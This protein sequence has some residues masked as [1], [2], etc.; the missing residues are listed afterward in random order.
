MNKSRLVKLVILCILGM[1]LAI[2]VAIVRVERKVE[3][4]NK[5]TTGAGQVVL[6]NYDCS[7]QYLR[8]SILVTRGGD[9]EQ[10]YQ[11][12]VFGDAYNGE[13]CQKWA[14]VPKDIKIG[15]TVEYYARPGIAYSEGDAKNLD[16]CIER[17]H[18]SA[19]NQKL[20]NLNYYVRKTPT[21]DG[22]GDT[23]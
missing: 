15:D 9:S 2:F 8:C 3:E 17:T 21:L 20:D 18:K 1:V 16:L 22:K 14:D 7:H 5:T 4:D 6:V 11:N 23:K 13:W 10:I 19:Y 12:V